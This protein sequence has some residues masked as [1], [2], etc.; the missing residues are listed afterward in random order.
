MGKLKKV[1]F[2]TRTRISPRIKAPQSGTYN[3]KS[4][5]RILKIPSFYF[6]KCTNFLPNILLFIP[7][8]IPSHS[9]RVSLLKDC[10]KPVLGFLCNLN[11][12]PNF[13]IIRQD[14][15]DS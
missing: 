14:F 6:V 7:L 9:P 5:R 13:C 2:S 4:L 1:K 3:M 15:F 8:F 10:Q 11:Q 12:S